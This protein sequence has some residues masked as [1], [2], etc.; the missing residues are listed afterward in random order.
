MRMSHLI[1]CTIIVVLSVAVFLARL[2]GDSRLFHTVDFARC[3][4][5]LHFMLSVR[6]LPL[7]LRQCITLIEAIHFI[8]RGC[9]FSIRRHVALDLSY[10]LKG[11]AQLLNL[12]FKLNVLVY[13]SVDNVSLR[14]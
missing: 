1:F 2:E 10:I 8:F 12:L 5:R 11:T 3:I 9:A 6:H 7:A 4:R 13:Q 14:L